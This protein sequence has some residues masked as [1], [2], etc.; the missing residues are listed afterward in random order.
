M[1]GR[2]EKAGVKHQLVTFEGLDHQL[3]DAD[4]RTE[5]LRKSDEW[6][7]AAIGTGN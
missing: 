6:L 4:A 3:E 1:D 2:L 7:Q 5:M